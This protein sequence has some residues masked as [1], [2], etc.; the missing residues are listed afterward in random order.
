MKL[1]VIPARGGSKRI[2]RKNLKSFL[3]R[4]VLARTVSVALESGAFDRVIVSTDDDEIARVAREAGA[5]VPFTRPPELAD[6]HATTR[7]VM[8]HAIDR[9]SAEGHRPTIVG[10]LYPAAVFVT[11]DDLRRAVRLVEE[12]PD[13][14]M[15]MTVG[16]YPRSVLRALVLEDGRLR[17]ALDEYR[18]TRSQDLPPTYFDAG[19]FY[20]GRT[21]HW[22]DAG[23]SLVL[24]AAP[25]VIEGV[26]DID[27]EAD[28]VR[29]EREL[30]ERSA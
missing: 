16:E 2:P 13:V 11:A 9:V 14:P 7:Q 25:V 6:D 23:T 29:A 30:S 27:T 8:R 26:I 17:A 28:W 5:D 3:G 12:R 10:C 18:R 21:D 4:P 1:L 20:V 15:V 19:Q 24:G 22:E